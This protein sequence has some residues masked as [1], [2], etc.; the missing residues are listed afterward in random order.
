M[1]KSAY[2]EDLRKKIGHDLLLIPG[3][4][5]IIRDREGRIL[6]Q[7]T[8][9]GYWNLPAGAIDPGEKPAQAIVREV[10]EETGLV[11]RPVSLI[12]VTGGPPEARTEYENGDLVEST[13]TIFA[14]EIVGGELKPQDDET[15]KLG[16]FAVD[17]MPQIPAEYKREI[18]AIEGSAA[19]F[20]WNDEW[21]AKARE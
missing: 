16:Y 9:S 20:E 18:F 13:T 12:G 11:A 5:A 15:L 8:K 7:R 6:L 2:V 1:S 17:E 19:F 21:L 4:A 10:F 3:V 14:C